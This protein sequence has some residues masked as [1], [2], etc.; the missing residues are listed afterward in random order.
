MLVQAVVGLIG[1]GLHLKAD[2]Y[3]VGPTIFDRVVY[4]APIFA[5]M[6]F[7][8]L[9]ALACIGLWALY[10]RLPEATTKPANAIAEH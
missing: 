1:F 8:D 7:P 10:Q 5:P 3:G 2:L 9:V 4:G 6:L